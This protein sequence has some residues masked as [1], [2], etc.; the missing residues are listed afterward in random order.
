MKDTAKKPLEIKRSALAKLN[1]LGKGNFGE[2][3]RGLYSE[4]ES[5]Q[6]NVAI[7]SFSLQDEDS[8]SNRRMI[9]GE[10]TLMAQFHNDYVIRLIGVVSVS[11]P[12]LIIM[13]YCAN[14]DLETFLRTYLCEHPLKVNFA[15]E[16]SQGMTYLASL[17]FIHQDLA[18]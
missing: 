2:V 12:F 10:A 1:M 13:E 4:S 8:K 18:S 6:I 14:G 7:K 9:L 5:N 17:K 11:D 15:W 3:Y 16:I